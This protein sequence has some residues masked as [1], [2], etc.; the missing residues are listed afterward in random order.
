MCE[1]VASAPG[2]AS[3]LRWPVTKRSSTTR[4]KSVTP[5]SSANSKATKPKA[6]RSI[7]KMPECSQVCTLLLQHIRTSFAVFVCADGLIPRIDK[8]DLVTSA[9]AAP[10]PSASARK[11]ASAASKRAKAQAAENSVY[12]TEEEE[13]VY[14]RDWKLN[15]ADERV[16]FPLLLFL[17]LFSSQPFSVAHTASTLLF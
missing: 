4:P 14:E 2:A 5:R 13:R 11:P 3:P 8:C 9:T 17:F 16:I 1:Q 7:K 15:T 10:G 12:L 6:C